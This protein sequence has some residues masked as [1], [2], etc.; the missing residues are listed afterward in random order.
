[1]YL[2]RAY[3]FYTWYKCHKCGESINH[4]HP[5]CAALGKTFHIKCFTCKECNKLLAGSAFY[6][7]GGEPLCEED[8]MKTLERCTS[9]GKPIKGK[10]LR[11]TGSAYHAECFVCIDCKKCLDEAPFATDSANNVHCVK[12]FH[13]KYAPRCAVCSKQIMPENDSE[14][15]ERIVAMDKSFHVDCFRCED[16]HTLLNSE[17]EGQGCYPLDEHLYCKICNSKRLMALPNES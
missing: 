2:C 14:G 6:N 15:S 9:C 11:A 5:G 7:V 10:L 16:C 12:C 4:E 1:M 3:T 8:H 13:D 17:I